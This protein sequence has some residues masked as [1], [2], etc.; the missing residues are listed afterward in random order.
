[1]YVLLLDMYKKKGGNRWYVMQIDT[2]TLVVYIWT[3]HY[4]WTSL[5]LG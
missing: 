1:M 5:A 2:Q 4:K 3:R